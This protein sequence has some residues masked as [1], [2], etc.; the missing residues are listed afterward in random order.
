MKIKRL[1][2]ECVSDDNRHLVVAL[3][4]ID[5]ACLRKACDTDIDVDELLYQLHTLTDD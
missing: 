3:N 2:V 1:L 4:I 5:N